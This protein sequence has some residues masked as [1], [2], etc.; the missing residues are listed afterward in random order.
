M[1]QQPQRKEINPKFI[2]N[3]QQAA[4][5]DLTSENIRLK[6]YIGQLE[7]EKAKLQEQLTEAK[8]PSK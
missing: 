5:F 2:F 3:E 6:A 1:E 4:I 8:K 7:E